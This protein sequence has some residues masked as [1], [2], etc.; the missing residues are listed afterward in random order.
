LER[1]TKRLKNREQISSPHV[2]KGRDMDC[3]WK[4]QYE[5]YWDAALARLAVAAER[6]AWA[7][8][9]SRMNMTLHEPDNP[10]QDSLRRTERSE[11][12]REP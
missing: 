5:A 11:L 2:E 3:D 12:N 7:E 6:K 8:E 1:G 10:Q 4:D 9:T